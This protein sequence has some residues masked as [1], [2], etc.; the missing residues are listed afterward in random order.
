VLYIKIGS[1]NRAQ[2]LAII[3]TQRYDRLGQN[4]GFA[5]TYAQIDLG[6]AVIHFIRIVSLDFQILGLQTGIFTFNVIQMQSSLGFPAVDAQ[7]SHA[8]KFRVIRDS[9]IRSY[10]DRRFLQVHFRIDLFE[11]DPGLPIQCE[12]RSSETIIRILILLI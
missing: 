10:T 4:D 9:E 1:A 12:F 7:T 2:S 6:A 5:D 3:L 11:P 8:R